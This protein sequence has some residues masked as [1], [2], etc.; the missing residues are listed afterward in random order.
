MELVL[1]S[2][3]L[4]LLASLFAYLVIPRFGPMTL[5]IVSLVALVVA[6]VDHY[7]R[8]SNEYR[9]STWQAAL[10]EYSSWIVLGFSLV[11][12]ILFLM[13]MVAFAKGGAVATAMAATSAAAKNETVLEKVTTLAQNSI[14]AVP[15][16][17]DSAK[18][19]TNPI[20]ATVN[21]GL[22][23][24]GINTTAA[25]AKVNEPKKLNEPKKPNAGLPFSPSSI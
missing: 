23:A 25:P 24:M 18:N 1:P 2:I 19:T 21:K 3:F 11:I 7:N 8:F 12:A 10:R 20:V 9:L 22:N 17:A 4:L 15:T 13:Q 16:V 5:A 14:A 6:I